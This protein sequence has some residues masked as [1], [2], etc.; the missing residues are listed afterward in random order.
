MCLKNLD[1]T[2]L[3]GDFFTKIL[4]RFG[5]GSFLLDSFLAGFLKDSSN[6]NGGS[7]RSLPG[8][9]TSRDA[10]VSRFLSWIVLAY[11]KTI[12]HHNVPWRS[13]KGWR[14]CK[15]KWVWHCHVY[16]WYRAWWYSVRNDSVDKN[17]GKKL[18]LVYVFIALLPLGRV[19]EK[20]NPPLVQFHL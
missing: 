5:E 15:G 13:F 2:D 7:G 11:N 1:V 6:G 17:T 3:L 14:T 19:K 16:S 4:V 18:V 9:R 20:W 12:L 8:W 10:R